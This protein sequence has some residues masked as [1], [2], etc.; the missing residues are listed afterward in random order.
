VLRQ[1]RKQLLCPRCDDVV[2]VP[3]IG[4]LIITSVESCQVTPSGWALQLRWVEQ[5]LALAS[6]D[7]RAEAQARCDFV[8]RNVGEVIYDIRCRRGHSTLRVLTMT[9]ELARRAVA[10][11]IIEGSISQLRIAYSDSPLNTDDGSAGRHGPR[12]GDRAR[13]LHQPRGRDPDFGLLRGIPTPC[14]F[15]PC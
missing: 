1:V 4:S 13:G 6:M 10:V 12:P 9:V 11:R 3:W 2:Y 7:D 14:C 8:S 5:D 15:L